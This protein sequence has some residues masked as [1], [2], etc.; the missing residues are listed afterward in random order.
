MIY[1]KLLSAIHP[2]QKEQKKQIGLCFAAV[3]LVASLAAIPGL[4]LAAEDDLSTTTPD[5]MAAG[6]IT[7]SQPQI[8]S[9]KNEQKF[10]KPKPVVSGKVE[11]GDEALVFID[12]VFNGVAPITDRKFAYRPFLPL[13]SGRHTVTVVA[14]D[15]KSG[16][17][18]AAA[19][20]T[21]VITTNPAP[22]LLAPKAGTRLGQSRV[23][24]GG[25]TKN[26][27]RVKVLVDQKEY[28]WA[29]VMNHKS[30]TAS[31]SLELKGLA[32]GEHTVLA[33]ARDK[34]GKDSFLSQP[35]AIKVLPKTPTPVLRRP[36]VNANA[37]IERPFIVGLVRK[38]LIVTVVIDGRKVATMSTRPGKAGV[39][40]FSWQPT[41]PLALGRHKIE[42]FASDNGK[43]SNNSKAV[44]WQVGEV[45]AGAVGAPEDKKNKVTVSPG[46]ATGRVT[47]KDDTAGRIKADEEAG[48][49][50]ASAGPP[51]GGATDEV[52]EVG[53]GAVV[54]N[55][56][57]E[58]GPR[59][60]NT[61][62]II[63]IVILAF[64]VISIII[65]YIQERRGRVSDKV[66]DMFR[67]SEEGEMGK[68]E[69]KK[70]EEERWPPNEPSPRRDTFDDD[71]FPPPPPPM[72]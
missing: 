22:T 50:A 48:G 57:G 5:A 23:W 3:A 44:W 18:S 72:F 4:T 26:N 11:F 59:R 34:F 33:M 20:V 70:K 10:G 56:E 35:L 31:F 58:A 39:A 53:P 61:S 38:D 49:T 28:G 15:K 37:G 17:K 1:A 45:A 27:S 42:A 21:F 40:S 9:P 64:L 13:A 6:Q 12:E 67:E 14:R 69:E 2:K 71:N 46:A 24:V 32:L 36:V 47:V 66:M 25:V 52:R 62:L 19:V 68:S 60:F 55:L 63:G 43:L 65:W 7:L 30:G 41:K 51:T 29:K 54:R 16:E 8:T